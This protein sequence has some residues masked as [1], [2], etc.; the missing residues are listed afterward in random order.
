LTRNGFSPSQIHCE[1]LPIYGQSAIFFRTG[2]KSCSCSCDGTRNL[3]DDA[4][5]GRPR[6]ND[7]PGPIRSMRQ[8]T[9]FRSCR[10]L[11]LHFVIVNIMCLRILHQDL[12]IE[13]FD[14]H[15]L[16][17][18]LH[19]SQKAKRVSVSQELLEDLLP[20]SNTLSSTVLPETSLGS[21]CTSRLMLSWSNLEMN[22]LEQPGRRS[23]LTN[24]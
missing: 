13:K 20:I 24:L 15:R 19:L 1:P 16:P 23:T 21:S 18:T 9:S 3:G 8:E 5:S 22:L 12:G 7:M 14:R 10:V 6:P 11:S 4:R 17:H 2:A